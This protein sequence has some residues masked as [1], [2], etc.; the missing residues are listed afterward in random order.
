MIFNETIITLRN[1]DYY[2]KLLNNLI[3]NGLYDI[4]PEEEINYVK[5]L[6][7]LIEFLNKNKRYLKNFRSK[8][9]ENIIILC[10]DEILTKKFKKE[11]DVEELQSVILLVKNSY[12][13]R[14][15]LNKIKD[16]YLKMYYKYKCNFCFNQNDTE[17]LETDNKI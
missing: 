1:T 7:N 14:N 15:F 12:L 2:I 5:I 11:V 6:I 13:F 17:V 3:I 9:Y 8:N 16:F 4:I 10:I